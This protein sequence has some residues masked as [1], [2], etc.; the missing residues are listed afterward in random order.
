[1]HTFFE[2]IDME[3]DWK[4]SRAGRPRKANP[5]SYVDRMERKYFRKKK[6]I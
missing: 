1:V 3:E 2:V 5:L 4:V 6:R